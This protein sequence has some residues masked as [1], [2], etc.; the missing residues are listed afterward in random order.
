[1]VFWDISSVFRSAVFCEASVYIVYLVLG[2]T[3]IL[4]F[5]FWRV[6]PK[7]YSS[8]KPSGFSLVG[9]LRFWLFG[10]WA[11]VVYFIAGFISYKMTT[12]WQRQIFI[13]LVCAAAFSTFLLAS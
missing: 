7:E 9:T 2:L 1:M 10:F 12:N 11:Q 4:L 13:Y 3:F 6:A 8:G 5:A